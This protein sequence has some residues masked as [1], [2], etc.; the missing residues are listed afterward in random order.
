MRGN[1]SNLIENYIINNNIDRYVILDDH[2]CYYLKENDINNHLVLCD[3]DYGFVGQKK[4]DEA[5]SVLNGQK[6]LK[7]SDN[8]INL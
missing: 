4:Y 6:V 1:R 5:I 7:K 3:E 8:N 2:S